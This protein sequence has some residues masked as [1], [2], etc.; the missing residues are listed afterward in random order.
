MMKKTL[1]T[2]L[3]ILFLGSFLTSESDAAEMA[4]H[5]EQPVVNVGAFYNGTTVTAAGTAPAGAEIVLLVSGKPENLHLKKKGKA[6]GLLWMNVGD[7]TFANAPGVYQLYTTAGGEALTRSPGM[8]FSYAALEKRVRIEPVDGNHDRLFEEFLKL[9]EGES[10]YAIHPGAVKRYGNDGFQV[11]LSIPPRMKPEDY[12]VT[13]YAVE[14]E[15]VIG[16]RK[17]NLAVQQVGFPAWLSKMAFQNALLYGI[18]SVLIALAAGFIMGG[19][20]RGGD[21]AH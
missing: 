5:L 4:L 11:S 20:F 15:K 2:F 12:A 8:P 14:N 3:S 1:L 9:K 18:L 13:V 17:A 10:V 21:G 16:T 7:L 6:G 19:L